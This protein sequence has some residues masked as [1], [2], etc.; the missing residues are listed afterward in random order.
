M[1][2]KPNPH[3]LPSTLPVLFHHRLSCQ[4]LETT[5]SGRMGAMRTRTLMHHDN[6]GG[7]GEDEEE[8]EEKEEKGGM[9]MRRKIENAE[10]EKVKAEDE[11]RGR[12]GSIRRGGRGEEE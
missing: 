10:E 4:D 1:V 7:R 3:P 8:E 5:A 11:G 9:K 2:T 12:K 6:A